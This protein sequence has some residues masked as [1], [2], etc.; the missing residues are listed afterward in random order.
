MEVLQIV[1]TQQPVIIVVAEQKDMSATLPKIHGAK[2]MGVPDR[3]NTAGGVPPQPPLQQVQLPAQQHVTE[4]LMETD[5]E[6]QHHI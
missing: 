1:L 5:M 3:E 2:Q 6:C 4:T